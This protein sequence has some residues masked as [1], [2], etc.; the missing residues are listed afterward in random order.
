MATI[1]FRSFFFLK[2]LLPLEE[3]QCFKKI[4]FLLDET[5]FLNFFRHWFTWKQYFG[6]LKSCFSTNPLFGLVETVP[7]NYKPFGFIQ[8]FLFHHSCRPFFKGEY[9]SFLLKLFS[10][11]LANIP[12]SG[13]SFFRLVETKIS[14]NPLSRLVYADFGLVSNRVLYS[15]FFF[16]LLESITEIGCIPVFFNFS[17]SNKGSSFSG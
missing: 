13:S 9:Y 8:S 17:V 15:D 4:L 1:L 6:P 11:V 7:V 10:W 12:A 5:V 14:S 16:L 3:D 2:P